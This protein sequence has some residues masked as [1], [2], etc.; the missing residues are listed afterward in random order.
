MKY[1]LALVLYVTGMNVPARCQIIST[2]AGNGNAGYGGDGG[3]AIAAQLNSPLGVALDKNGNIYVADRFNH[4]IRKVWTDGQITTVAG[5]GIAG[6]GGD[7]GPA[8]AAA[9]NSPVSV[10]VDG[11]GNLYIA[12]LGNQRIRKVDPSGKILTIAGNGTAGFSGDGGAATNAQLNAPRGVC[13]DG[14]GNILIADAGNHCIRKAGASGIITTI[15]GTP[16]INGFGGDGGNAAGAKLYGPYCVAADAAGNIYIADVDNQRIRKINTAG[17]ITTVAGTGAGGYS[18]DGGPATRAALYEPISVAADGAGNV[19]IADGWNE[20]IRMVDAAGYISTVAGNG[21]TGFSGDGGLGTAAKLYHPYS[22]AVDG[23]GNIYVADNGNNRV[24]K[25]TSAPPDLFIDAFP[26]PA[27]YSIFV[28]VASFRREEIKIV[29]TD[30]M[31]RVV[32]EMP[33]CLTNT[34]IRVPLETVPAGVYS[35]GAVSA[36]SKTWQRIVLTH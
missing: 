9:L 8:D 36:K 2:I 20:R 22:V 28:H 10:S 34:T 14:A 30:I 16:G 33:G 1:I 4:R 23:E 32:N 3:K 11:E 24:R 12:D 25:V 7:G 27:R 31:G 19:Y 18:G 29:V 17:I 5:N 6:Y 35:V 21:V 15:A 26:N 13:A